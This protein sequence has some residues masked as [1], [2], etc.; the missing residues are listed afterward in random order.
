MKTWTNAH[1]LWI[2]LAGAAAVAVAATVTALVLT[3]SGPG[4][5]RALPPARARTYTDQQ[6]CLLTGERGLA[7]PAAAPVWAGMRDASAGTHAKV[8]YLAMAGE[9]SAAAAGPYLATLADRKCTVVLTVGAG[10]D[11]AVP[12]AGPKFPGTRFVV[13]GEKAVGEKAGGTGGTADAPGAN[14]TA[15]PGGSAAST[16]KAVEAAVTDALRH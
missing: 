5:E 14:V 15:V 7:D 12:A 11:G 13:V 2:L 8:S 16:R 3:S 4:K 6:A 9:Q 10:P 1:R